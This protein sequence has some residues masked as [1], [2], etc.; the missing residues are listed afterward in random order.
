M[1]D[2]N[3]LPLLP[4][5][6]L[7]GEDQRQRQPLWSVTWGA[8]MG[9]ISARNSLPFA[10]ALAASF[11]G[12]EIAG[13]RR[14]ILRRGFSARVGTACEFNQPESL[15]M[16]KDQ[17]ETDASLPA[18]RVRGQPAH[19]PT[20]LDRDTGQADG[21]RRDHSR[22]TSRG[23]AASVSRPCASTTGRNW[24]T[25]RQS[26]TRWSSSSTSRRSSAATSRRSNGGNRPAWAGAATP[27]TRTAGSPNQSMRVVVEFVGE[28]GPV[29]ID[30]APQP[31]D[32]GRVDLRKHVQ[33]VG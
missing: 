24:T 30:H 16:P 6:K 4:A 2:R 15:A 20:K 23:P 33:L 21:R 12:K 3:A 5:C 1:T 31:D 18:K 26:S 7:L 19:A 25:E 13:P 27:A 28:P 17:P 32:R 11:G 29:T 10:R 9:N 8:A 22:P 14:G